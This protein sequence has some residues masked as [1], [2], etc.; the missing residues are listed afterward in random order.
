MTN[1]PNKT[2]LLPREVQGFLNISRATLYRYLK[3]GII[4]S[5][6]VGEMYRV[7][8]EEF[9]EW[10]GSSHNRGQAA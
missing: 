1:L 4:P 2:H 7:P 6:R 9:M 3:D 5:V 8:R 10:Y